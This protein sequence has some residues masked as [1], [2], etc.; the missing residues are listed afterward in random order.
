MKLENLLKSLPLPLLSV[1]L[2]GDVGHTEKIFSLVIFT[3]TIYNAFFCNKKMFNLV[4]I[5]MSFSNL[6][7]SIFEKKTK[8]S[9][10]K[11]VENNI[12]MFLVLSSKF[13]LKVFFKFLSEFGLI[14]N[15]A[16][17]SA[18]FTV[19]GIVSVMKFR[20]RNLKKIE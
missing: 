8:N 5:I 6:C 2:L 1:T 20:K 13:S 11:M 10:N 15:R 4:L 18:L 7:Y 16:L 12:L 17:I 19:S 14:F 9:K 3:A